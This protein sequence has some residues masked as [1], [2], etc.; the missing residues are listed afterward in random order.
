MGPIGEGNRSVIKE[1]PHGVANGSDNTFR[2][3]I[4]RR[5]VWTRKAKLDTVRGKEIVKLVV[6]KFFS[7][8]AL[9][10]FDE[11]IKLSFS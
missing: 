6:V 9:K 10:G 1:S 11:T 2:F 7:I 5:S 3:P 8:I 4:L